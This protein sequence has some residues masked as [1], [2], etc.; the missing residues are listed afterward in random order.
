M[1]AVLQG[2][3]K[4]GLGDEISLYLDPRR[5]FVFDSAGNL[6]AAPGENAGGTGAH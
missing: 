6:V 3:H 1:I 2:V 4:F 5:L